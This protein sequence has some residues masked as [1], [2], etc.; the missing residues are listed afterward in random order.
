MENIKWITAKEAKQK[1]GISRMC[2][3]LWRLKNKIQSKGEIVNGRL[4]YLY[5]KD[6]IRKNYSR[7]GKY[8]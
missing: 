5:N 1:Y 6:E 4:T 3:W 8:E 2:L 7:R